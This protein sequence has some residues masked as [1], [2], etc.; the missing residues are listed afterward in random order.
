MPESNS[1]AKTT[2]RA[3]WAAVTEFRKDLH[4]LRVRI[5]VV[6]RKTAGIRRPGRCGLCGEPTL[7][8]YCRIHDWM[9]GE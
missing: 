7:N 2:A 5:G 3:A 1:L 4:A 9:E 8:R 6:E